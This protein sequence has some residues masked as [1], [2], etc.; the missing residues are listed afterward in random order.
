MISGA[1]FP[2]HEAVY[3]HLLLR[4]DFYF[5]AVLYFDD[6]MFEA[7]GYLYLATVLGHFDVIS[8]Q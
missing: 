7:Q 6:D 2:G 4:L 8:T 5:D 3:W 1:S